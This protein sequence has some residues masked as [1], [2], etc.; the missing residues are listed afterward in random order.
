MN[1]THVVL[2]AGGIGRSA[3]TN[4]AAAGHTV[5]LGSR[6]GSDPGIDGVRGVAVD[7][8]DAAALTRLAAG[9]ASIINAINPKLYTHWDRDGPPVA[10]AVLAAAQRTGA[11][12]V[13]VSNLYGYGRVEAPMTERTP[14]APVGV[15]G[16][17]RAQMWTDALAAHQAGRVRATELRAGAYFGPGASPGVSYLNTYVLAPAA[18]GKTVRLVTGTPDAVQSWTYLPDI[19]SFAAVLATD[20]RSWGRPWHVPTEPPKSVRA[21][22]TD[23]AAVTGGR[24]SRVVELPTIARLALRVLPIV[25]ALDETRHQFER[26]FIIDSTAAEQTFGVSSTPWREALAATLRPGVLQPAR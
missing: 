12:L 18:A 22:A 17:V 5:I 19:G 9:A 4:L 2:G 10:A 11:G 7:A 16:R 14:F 26:P 13:T 20:D 6:R 21:I 8:G 25:R 23:V 1:A 3:A 24:V 15:K